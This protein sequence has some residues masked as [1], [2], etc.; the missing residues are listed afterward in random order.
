MQILNICLHTNPDAPEV[1]EERT[2]IFNFYFRFILGKQNIIQ[3]EKKKKEI[4]H[5]NIMGHD[6]DPRHTVKAAE[7]WFME[8]SN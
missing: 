6:N 5:K 2:S 7:V 3:R 4:E 1:T 8:W